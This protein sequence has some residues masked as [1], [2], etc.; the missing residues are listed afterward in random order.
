[1]HD[2]KPNSEWHVRDSL[3]CLDLSIPRHLN[4]D[5]GGTVHNVPPNFSLGVPLVGTIATAAADLASV[6]R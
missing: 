2:V 4:A 6:V 3:R 1:M 5:D